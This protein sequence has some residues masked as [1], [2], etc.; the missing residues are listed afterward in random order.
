MKALL[1]VLGAAL[2]V[3]GCQ[4]SA[5]VRE[6][7]GQGFVQ[8]AGSKLQLKQPL[9]VPAGRARVFI[10]GGGAADAP[11]RVL[12]G[13]FDHYRPH[14]AFEIERVDH[15]GWTIEPDTFTITLVQG[16]LVQVVSAEPIRL[17]GMR[18]VGGMDSP[19]S[20][21]YHQGYHFWLD[22]ERQPQVRRMTC[23]GVFAEPYELYPPTLQEIREALGAIAEI[24]R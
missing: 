2:L 14:C 24:R 8:L 6:A 10:Q 9:L 1:I 20:S 16:S 17:A 11:S 18:L 19:G 23:Y 7:A 3:G 4:N 21:A 5:T 13:G 12:S 22:S 15:S